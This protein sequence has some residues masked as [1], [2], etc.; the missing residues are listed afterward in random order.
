MFC[1]LCLFRN[2]K[3][4]KVHK[5][6]NWPVNRTEGYVKSPGYPNYYPGPLECEWPLKAETGQ[7]MRVSILDL[8]LVD[9]HTDEPHCADR[10]RLMDGKAKLLDTCGERRNILRQFESEDSDVTAQLNTHAIG[11]KRG[12][13]LWFKAF[14]C[15]TL[16][17]P[18][19]GYL[20]FRNVTF[21]QYMCCTNHYFEDNLERTRNLH[22][23]D[24]SEWSS[25]LASCLDKKTLKLLK[26]LSSFDEED[27]YDNY[28][29][30]HK[31]PLSEA[32]VILDILV[33]SV[34]MG[35]LVL[36]NAIIVAVLLKLRK[37]VK[38]EPEAFDNC[39]SPTHQTEIPP[40]APL[41][42][43]KPPPKPQPPPP[44]PKPVNSNPNSNSSHI[45]MK[46]STSSEQ[47]RPKH[48]LVTEV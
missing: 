24:G 3:D 23:I 26:N 9:S 25:G 11:A 39:T 48:K 29:S 4:S 1:S 15:R 30:I 35:I 20:V 2:F 12:I 27:D 34:I 28:E 22:C 37:S 44:P 38:E 45:F 46:P 41:T 7:R 14:G 10:F 31:V 8:S 33:P 21:A 18:R 17:A 5:I 42:R 13:L 43:I 6:C 47:M 19:H 16:E 32:D 36:G 40:E